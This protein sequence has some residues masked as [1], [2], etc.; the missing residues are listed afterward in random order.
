MTTNTDFTLLEESLQ[1]ADKA[2]SRQ[3]ADEFLELM[4]QSLEIDSEN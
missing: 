1:I 3:K 2:I 4:K